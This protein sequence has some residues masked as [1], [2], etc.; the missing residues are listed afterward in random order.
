MYLVF[1]F[2]ELETLYF[3]IQTLSV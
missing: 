3:R 2:L 1:A